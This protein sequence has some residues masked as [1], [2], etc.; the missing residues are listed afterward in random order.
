MDW[1][2]K[3][4]T[5]FGCVCAGSAGLAAL[6]GETAKQPLSGWAKVEFSGLLGTSVASFLAVLLTGAYA[7]WLSFAARNRH[8]AGGAI[9]PGMSVAPVTGGVVAPVPGGVKDPSGTAPRELAAYDTDLSPE[10]EQVL[11]HA[12]AAFDE[13]LGIREADDGF[14]SGGPSMQIL[15]RLS[16]LKARL[17][18]LSGI[19]VG[20]SRSASWAM[21]V[22]SAVRGAEGALRRLSDMDDLGAGHELGELRR[23]LRELQDL[24][25][26]RY[27]SLRGA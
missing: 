14:G 25:V 22:A 1:G 17:G 21:Q 6:V 19:T 10:L 11:R 27:P 12:I 13:F 16:G 26:G 20:T 8:D 7:L 9:A 4:A 2:G 24:M 3:V 15:L 23:S 5:W 18:E